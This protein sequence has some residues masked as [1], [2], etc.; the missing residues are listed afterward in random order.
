MRIHILKYLLT[1]AV[2]W[3]AVLLFAVKAQAEVFEKT[4]GNGLKV[5]VKED[6]RAPVIV[7]Q[8][9]YRAGSMDENIGVTGI[10]H[11]L[12]HMMFKGT[13][14]V[15][16]G[17]FSKRISAAGGRE[18][19]FTSNDY[20]AYFQQLH[21]S[22]LP[23]AMQLES[24]RM[25]NLHLTE[26]EFSKEIKVVMEE[27]RMRTDDEPHALMNEKLMA[28]AFQEHPYRT[29]VIGWMN[30][31]QTLSVNDAK[32]WYKN[33]YVPNNA[34]LVVAGDVK[35]SEVFA[36]AQRF[37]GG[38]PARSLPA[39][40]HF[41]EPPQLGVK[42][43]V[44]KAPAQLPQLVMAYHAPSLRDPEKDWQPYAL[45]ILAG[46][47][48][49]NASA[50]LNK[51]LV[52]EKQLASDV[53]AEYDATSRGPS[54][55]MLEGTPSEGKSVAEIEE[56]LR[57]QI[58]ILKR[59][60]VNEDEL[61]RAKAQVTASEVYKLDSLFYQAMQIGQMESMGLSYKTI[62]L[63]LKKLQAVTAQQVQDVAREFLQDD[64]L[65]IAVLEPQ[66]LSG[67]PKQMNKG[68]SHAH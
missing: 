64:Q 37:Y 66:P 40:K 65:T 32:T 19:A 33:W 7:Q 30:D 41:N 43:I 59:D 50:R 45:Q 46:I 38:I 21:K 57:E 18:N 55:F 47:L 12:E 28:V 10:A 68:T 13:K 44:V 17:Q 54:L 2:L 1:I 35:A 42:R 22:K 39:R 49:G 5:I 67:K 16:V 24:D 27:R 4:L 15:P 20:T 63:I 23:L 29:P 26:T 34:T 53:G 9:W 3:P 25:R 51:T 60:G 58:A 52:R 56:G 31:L 61:K 14:N 48:D 11:V 36:L 62:P 6:H 8:I